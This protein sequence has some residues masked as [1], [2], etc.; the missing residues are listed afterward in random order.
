[1]PE[2]L[3]VLY[4][5]FILLGFLAV[6]LFVEGAY[7]A[8]NSYKGPEARRIERRLRFMSAGGA[9]SDE[10][11]I[12]K[13]RLLAKT[14]WMERLF[15]QVPRIHALD[16][17]LVQS[18]VRMSVAM[19]FGL[20]IVLVLA[21][22]ILTWIFKLPGWII[23]L[24]AIMF[25][26]FPISYVLNA[27]RKRLAMIDVQLPDALDLIARAL[28]AGH[29]FPSAIKMVGDECPEP[30]SAEFAVVFDEINYGISAQDALVN[31]STRVPSTDLR[32]FVISVLIQRDTGGNL[33]E[34]LSQ[35]SAL[36]RAR[37][38]L[39]G[40]VRVLSAEGRLSAWI[41]SLLPFVL[42]F[43]IYLL[44]PRFIRLLWTDPIGPS[45]IAGALFIMVLG[46]F[47]MRRIIRI[48]I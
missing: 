12:V 37:Q 34:I 21:G 27:R 22:G 7:L 18:G 19:F 24:V 26:F 45:L 1:M 33:A 38:R 43:I 36:I 39:V 4:Y 40:S 28:Q 20:T 41:L 9:R 6:V 14:P 23:L 10:I 42:G 44:N 46:I 3:D 30:V 15:L 5:L 16:K 48:H 31:L 17:L 32:Y 2:E 47:W 11:S 13:Q 29:A 35:I 25:G 8:W